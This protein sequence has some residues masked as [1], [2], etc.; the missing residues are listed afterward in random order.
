[1]K[2][3]APLGIRKRP[4]KA[5]NMTQWV[6]WLPN[7]YNNEKLGMLVPHKTDL[8]LYMIAA[9]YEGIAL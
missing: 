6:A 4:C 9:F 5:Q 1:M 8:H 2:A 3:S 7:S